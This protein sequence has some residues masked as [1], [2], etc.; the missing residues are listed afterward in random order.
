M[1][2]SQQYKP[3]QHESGGHVPGRFKQSR[4]DTEVAGS[5][6]KGPLRWGDILHGMCEGRAFKTKG[7]ATASQRETSG[8]IAYSCNKCIC[9]QHILI[10]VLPKLTKQWVRIITCLLQNPQVQDLDSFFSVHLGTIKIMQAPQL[11]RV[12]YI[13]E[14]YWSVIWGMTDKPRGSPQERKL[15]LE[16]LKIRSWLLKI[17]YKLGGKK[18]YTRV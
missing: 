1:G 12:W 4:K 7:T 15:L 13:N 3:I 17:H 16:K 2:W 8:T 18:E 6:G 9:L 10:R 11:T 14:D 5:R